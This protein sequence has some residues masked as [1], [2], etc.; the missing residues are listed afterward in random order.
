MWKSCLSE[1]REYIA[2]IKNFT[3][4]VKNLFNGADKYIN[5]QHSALTVVSRVNPT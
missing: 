1:N 3:Y 4:I 5:S 2:L